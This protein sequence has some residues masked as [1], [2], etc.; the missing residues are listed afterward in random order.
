MKNHELCSKRE[1]GLENYAARHNIYKNKC[2]KDKNSK[3]M[4]IIIRQTWTKCFIV[5]KECLKEFSQKNS[6]STLQQHNSKVSAGY[7]DYS[8]YLYLFRYLLNV[9]FTEPGCLFS[10][11]GKI[12]INVM[13]N[14]F[15]RGQFCYE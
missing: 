7:S 5:K 1:N 15:A 13:I 10:L 4:S 14:N 11:L 6:N 12:L 8:V 2:L 9:R 3:G